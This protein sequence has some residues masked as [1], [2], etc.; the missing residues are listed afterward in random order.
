MSEWK[1]SQKVDARIISWHLFH[2][3]NI[4]HLP[5]STALVLTQEEQSALTRHFFLFF[6]LPVLKSCTEYFQ[7]GNYSHLPR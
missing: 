5:L 2:L 1:T 7:N 3:R 4:G 6:F